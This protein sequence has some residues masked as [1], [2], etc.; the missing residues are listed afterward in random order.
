MTVKGKINLHFYTIS[1]ETPIIAII[2]N[3]REK[4][5]GKNEKSHQW[6][7]LWLKWRNQQEL[8]FGV[9]L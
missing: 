1:E 9:V 5:E 6:I 3:K 8:S 2:N 7:R 4:Y